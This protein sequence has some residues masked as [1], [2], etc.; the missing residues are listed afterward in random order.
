MYFATTM[1]YIDAICNFQAIPF[2]HISTYSNI[3]KVSSHS[4]IFQRI[5]ILVSL[6]YILL[7]HII[8]TLQLF[9]FKVLHAGCAGEAATGALPAA[10]L[11]CACLVFAYIYNYLYLYLFIYLYIYIYNPIPLYQL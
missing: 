3:F 8:P 11:V 6:L 9:Y 7:F 1:P 4:N 2:Q 5:P 10:M